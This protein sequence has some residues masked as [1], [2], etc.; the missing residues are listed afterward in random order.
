MIHDLQ[1]CIVCGINEGVNEHSRM[2]WLDIPLEYVLKNFKDGSN[3]DKNRKL[4]G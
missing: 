3:N 1:I 4:F 2:M